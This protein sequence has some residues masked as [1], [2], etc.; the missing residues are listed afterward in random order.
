MD[1]IVVYVLDGGVLW[2][3]GVR[4]DRAVPRQYTRQSSLRHMQSEA[5][6][7]VSSR[8]FQ[9]GTRIVGA[10]ARPASGS[11]ANGPWALLPGRSRSRQ[12]MGRRQAQAHDALDPTEASQPAAT[13]GQGRHALWSAA[14]CAWPK[15]R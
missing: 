7:L 1:Y 3:H 5:L 8:P 12:S 2:W 9:S 11:L 14:T 13:I 4:R 10:A 6:P 15:D